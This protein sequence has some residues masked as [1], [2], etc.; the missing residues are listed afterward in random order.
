MHLG[1][2]YTAT[3]LCVTSEE[4]GGLVSVF[5]FDEQGKLKFVCHHS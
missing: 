2:N 4:S 3:K 5:S 1:V